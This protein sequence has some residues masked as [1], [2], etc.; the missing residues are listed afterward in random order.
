MKKKE[1]IANVL[2]N[3][4]VKNA[5]WLIFGKIAQMCINLFVGLLTAR[6]LGPSNYGV[7]NYGSA[8]TAFFLNLC[9]L[10]I[11]SV[12]VKEFVDYPNEE[13]K[14]IGTTLGLKG[15]ASVLSAI[16]IMLI[17]SFIDAN[18]PT[19]ILV[20]ALCSIGLVFN[21]LD[22]FNY[23]FQSKLQSKVT[24][25]A[26]LIAFAVTAAYKVYLMVTDKSVVYF[27]FAT[28]IDYMC[29]GVLLILVYKRYKGSKLCFSWE[30][31]KR[32]LKSSTPFIIPG[33]M[34]AIYGQTDKMMLKQMISDAEI[35][36]YSTAVSICTMWCFILSA[37]ID[38][39][40]PI[41]MEAYN[42]NED[43]FIHKNR[44]LYT[45]IFYCC[46]FVSVFITV[47]AK[48]IVKML[49]GNAYLPTVNPLRIITWYTA[50]SYLGLARNAWIV[51]KNKQKYLTPVYASAAL[52]NVVL[53]LIFIPLY[54][55][56]GAA[57]ASLIAQIL[58]TL[59]IPFMIP[60]LKE[61]SKLM[62][63]AILFKG[64]WKKE[65]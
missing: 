62:I 23:W 50:F 18:E 53:N 20:V 17:S 12:L 63:E 21:I 16:S 43:D 11:N 31:G 65:H 1:K 6:Y 10:G 48:I 35:G 19:T 30:Y 7:I 58:T 51:C 47:F 24:A 32:L 45:I 3:R 56:S 14:I 22:T 4:V 39:M 46:I 52:A 54:G 34:V 2:N 9:T 42:E 40:Y 33:L 59:V 27:A 41:I 57:V 55:A 25:M 64:V 5:G 44:I 28:S 8:Y 15:V 36:Y 60:A 29:I 49:Y 61:N 37:I 38:S 26:S 13:G